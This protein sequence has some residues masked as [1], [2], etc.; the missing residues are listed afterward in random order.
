MLQ[1]AMLRILWETA[2]VESV[3]SRGPTKEAPHWRVAN[4]HR[5]WAQTRKCKPN[6]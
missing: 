3:A 1:D 5:I 4:E 2:W 6:L